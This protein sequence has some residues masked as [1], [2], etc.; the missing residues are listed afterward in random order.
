MKTILIVLMLLVS[1]LIQATE[2][3]RFEGMTNRYNLSSLDQACLETSYDPLPFFI[4]MEDMRSFKVDPNSNLASKWIGLCRIMT[5][6]SMMV[7]L[8]TC[9]QRILS[10]GLSPLGINAL[11]W[12][13]YC[14]FSLNNRKVQQFNSC[15]D[16]FIDSPISHD[17]VN[18]FKWIN[19]CRVSAHYDQVEIF[20]E[21][22]N[23]AL[24]KISNPESSRMNQE[25]K[26]CMEKTVP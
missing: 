6:K 9:S 11:S 22:M 26:S 13:G 2:C 14:E 18:A 3:P 24:A 20:T 16:H 10:S 15:M 1:S 17:G 21:C 4:C 25:I 23:D 5:L 12:V 19:G 7:E 8:Q